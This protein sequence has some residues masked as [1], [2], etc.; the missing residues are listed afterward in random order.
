[1]LVFSPKEDWREKKVTIGTI[2][3]DCS[4]SRLWLV[5]SIS[6]GILLS[7]DLSR[8]QKMPYTIKPAK[9]WTDMFIRST[10]WTGADGI[11]SM[12]LP[13][14]KTA[15]HP[16]GKARDQSQVLFIFSDSVIDTLVNGKSATQG[17]TMIHNAAAVLDGLKPKKNNLE[18]HWQ[19]NTNGQPASL[20]M[21]PTG[22]P[23]GPRDD[24]V[25]YW[26]G[27]VTTWSGKPN[28]KTISKGATSPALAIFAYRMITTDSSPF[29]FKD[30]GNDL[31]IT[32]RN[33]KVLKRVVVPVLEHGNFGAGIYRQ[34]TDQL[35]S[36]QT[37]PYIYIYG[38]RG[39]D[40]SLVVARTTDADLTVPANWEYYDGTSWT[41][42]IKKSKTITRHVSNELSVTRAPDGQYA[43]I[44]QLDGIQPYIG[45]RMAPTPYGPFSPMDTIWHCPQPA[46]DSNLLVYNAKAHPALSPEGKLLISYNVNS[47]TFLKTLKESPQ[48]YRPRFLWLKWNNVK[49]AK[50]G[51]K[52]GPPGP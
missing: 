20:F 41:N 16:P 36:G 18:F 27:D 23:G 49:K 9:S 35:V 32:D 7:P 39:M 44:F 38:V 43:L 10:G 8:A 19:K 33:F 17:F 4:Y 15:G 2:Q 13:P 42:N 14:N 50:T 5:V 6:L 11:Y 26:L 31:L 47:L 25:Y 28:N 22:R 1:M 51:T 34:D 45:L 37:A 3:K 52:Q 12:K 46:T 24:V 40:K 29:G 21:P 48:F 30:I